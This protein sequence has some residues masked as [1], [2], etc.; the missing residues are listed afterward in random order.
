[1]TT[2]LVLVRIRT[3]STVQTRTSTEPFPVLVRKRIAMTVHNQTRT[4]DGG[5]R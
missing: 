3:P 5:V 4:S 2:A 1:M